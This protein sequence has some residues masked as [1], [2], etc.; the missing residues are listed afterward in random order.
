[1]KTFTVV[2]DIQRRSGDGGWT[3]EELEYDAETP[4]EAQAMC[5]ADLW[6]SNDFNYF[7]IVCVRQ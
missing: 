5:E 2:F 4:E 3:R 1:M 7:D 6:E